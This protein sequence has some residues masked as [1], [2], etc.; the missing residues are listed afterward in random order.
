[1]SLHISQS[2]QGGRQAIKM[3]AVV[4][5]QY[6]MAAQPSTVGCVWMLHQASC[7]VTWLDLGRRKSL[8]DCRMV[9][10]EQEDSGIA[11]LDCKSG[12]MGL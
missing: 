4:C 3:N 7:G 6:Y 11:C 5:Y 10:S 9:W 8:A 1:M 12:Y 2:I